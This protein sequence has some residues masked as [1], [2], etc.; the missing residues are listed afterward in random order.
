MSL[1]AL[2]DVPV[3]FTGHRKFIFCLCSCGKELYVRQDHFKGGHTRSC[4]CLQRACAAEI[5]DRTS[6]HRLTGTLEYVA[7]NN[8][9][10]RCY[11]PQRRD[12]ERYGGRG[13]K[14]CARWLNSFE[15]FL[16]DMGKKPSYAHSLDR[17][18]NDGDYSPE[19]CR[20]ATYK[21]Q[22][23]N[24]RRRRFFRRPDGEP[25]SGA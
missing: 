2:R 9:K 22:N 17:I 21:E 16:A 3:K 18:N 4:G 7:W 1:L 10:C 15:N 6:T 20:W 8:M 19:N 24:R 13:I 11:L 14:V 12:Y 25:K 23:N 5:G